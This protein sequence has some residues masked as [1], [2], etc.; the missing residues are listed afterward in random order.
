MPVIIK[1][2]LPNSRDPSG[3]QGDSITVKPPTSGPPISGH[4][5]DRTGITVS[6]KI[7]TIFMKRAIYSNKA[8]ETTLITRTLLV[9]W[10]QITLTERSLVNG[11]NSL[12]LA[13]TLPIQLLRHWRAYIKEV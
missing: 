13:S 8:V 5:S 11:F 10:T 6:G 4:L 9:H 12:L 3:K 1:A 7:L 2:P